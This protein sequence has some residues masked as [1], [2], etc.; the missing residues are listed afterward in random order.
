M[1]EPAVWAGGGKGYD[2]ITIAR[3]KMAYPDSRKRC[4]GIHGGTEQ[5]GS[6]P[7]NPADSAV[8]MPDLR[9]LEKIWRGKRITIP[10]NERCI[11][12]G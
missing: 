9:G 2:E 7:Q 4:G 11:L 10:V 6:L 1:C 3:D 8:Q 5:C 12:H